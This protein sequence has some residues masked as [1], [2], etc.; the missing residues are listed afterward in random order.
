MKQSIEK[1]VCDSCGTI[2]KEPGFFINN[3]SFQE[4]FQKLGDKDICF[5]CMGKM[6][7][8]YIRI[9]KIPNDEVISLIDTLKPLGERGMGEEFKIGKFFGNALTA[10]DVIKCAQRAWDKVN[11]NDK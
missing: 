10:A 8:Q 2:L 7:S 4:T 1:I 5:S 6:F 9:N 3:G 11:K